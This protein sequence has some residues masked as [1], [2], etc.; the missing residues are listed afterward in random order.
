M[1]V[2]EIQEV[3]FEDYEVTARAMPAPVAAYG[4]CGED[5]RDVLLVYAEADCEGECKYKY[6]YPAH[7]WR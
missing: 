4:L 1:S 2:L 7:S 3:W 5:G 6:C